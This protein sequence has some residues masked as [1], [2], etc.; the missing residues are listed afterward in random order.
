MSNKFN[1]ILKNNDSF[2][3]FEYTDVLY[4]YCSEFTQ[5]LYDYVKNFTKNRIYFIKDS[6]EYHK[7]CILD[8]TTRIISLLIWCH[9]FLGGYLI[10]KYWF[11][12]ITVYN[13]P[14][15]N[16]HTVFPLTKTVSIHSICTKLN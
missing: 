5:E 11:H 2:E 16:V 15:I 7:L 14:S 3:N 9:Y 4:D 12:T 10:L 8:F 13:L 1:K 6:F